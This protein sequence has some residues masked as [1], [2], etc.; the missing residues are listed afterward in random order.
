M[1]RNVESRTLYDKFNV[2][3]VW[4]LRGFFRTWRRVVWYTGT[5]ACGVPVYQ[6]T[7]RQIPEDYD[8]FV[9]GPG[10]Y[11]YHCAKF[12]YLLYEK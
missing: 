11:K 9:Y 12:S 5:N 7:Q 10:N 3:K 6:T 8:L 1:V 4:I 2:Y